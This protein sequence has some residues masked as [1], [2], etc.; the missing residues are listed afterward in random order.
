MSPAPLA[1]R[2]A[3][4]TGG[5][6]GIGRAIVVELARCGAGVVF[7]YRSSPEGAEQ[8]RKL[9]AEAGGEVSAVA[10]DVADYAAVE[11]AIAG[12]LEARG[13]LDIVVNNAGIT[14]DQLIARMKPA[15]FAAVIQTNLGGT[16]NVCRAAVR[17]LLKNRWGRVI[18]ISSVVAQMGNPGQSNYAASKGGIEALTRSLAR[19]VGSRGITVNAVAPGFIDTDMTRDLGPG[20]AEGLAARIPLGRLGSVEDVARAV[21]FLASEDA[22]Y[23]TGQVIHVNGGLD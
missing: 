15:D 22:A 18:N 21:R 11:A 12:V 5:S 9:A 2:V 6:R 3:F 17:P 23:I 8:T 16:W 1:E 20:V 4:V 13:R 7:S 19:E 10:C 14:R